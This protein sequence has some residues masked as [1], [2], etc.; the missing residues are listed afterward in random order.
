MK[1]SQIDRYP[2]IQV[3]LVTIAILSLDGCYSNELCINPIEKFVENPSG[4]DLN[5]LYIETADKEFLI[6]SLSDKSHQTKFTLEGDNPDF[7]IKNSFDHQMQSFLLKTNSVYK[8]T[9]SSNGDAA[10]IS[11]IFQTDSL[12]HITVLQGRI[13]K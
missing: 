5:A 7:E 9:N 11:I 1:S 10:S 8:I 2:L 13:C 3:L 4:H 6:A 12:N